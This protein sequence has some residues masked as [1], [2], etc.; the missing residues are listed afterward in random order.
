MR[1]HPHDALILCSDGIWS[2]IEDK[3]FATLAID[4]E[5]PYHLG[6]VLIDLALKRHSDDNLSLVAIRVNDFEPVPDVL[7]TRRSLARFFRSR[8][9]SRGA[10]S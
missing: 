10:N 3:E 2:V 7:S 9:I 5:N 8:F 1:L 6:Q 4:L